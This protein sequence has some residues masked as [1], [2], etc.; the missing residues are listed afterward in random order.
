MA[1]IYGME[2]EEFDE[3]PKGVQASVKLAHEQQAEN[4]K[5]QE[6]IAE[7]EK[8][9]VKPEV[10]VVDENPGPHNNWKLEPYVIM[11]YETRRDQLMDQLQNGEDKKLAI[12]IKKYRA[13]I[14]T[15][16]NQNNPGNWAN[17]AFIQNAASI[18]VARHLSEILAEVKAGTNDWFTETGGAANNA[19][20]QN[21]VKDFNKLL[22]DEQKK[23]AKNF[24]LTLEQ[25]YDS[26]KEIGMV[27]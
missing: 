20:D 3:L 23:A 22:T 19:G 9:T 26:L 6:R 16:V 7:L 17:P 12:A 14:L 1:Q 8:V 11:G 4:V 10:K 25:Y 21:G 5:L 13:E 27:S 18:V 15:L 2:Q 24:G